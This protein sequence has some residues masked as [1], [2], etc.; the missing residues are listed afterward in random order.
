VLLAALGDRWDMSLVNILLAAHPAFAGIQVR[1]IDNHQELLL[2]RG[3]ESL[4]L[5]GKPGDTLS[6]IPV[7][8]RA[9]GITTRGLEYALDNGNLE[10]G[11][12]CGVSN[13]FCTNRASVSLRKG[14]LVCV[15][16]RN[17]GQT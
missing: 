7:R 12:P 16:I 3:G 6:L 17:G 9:E 10:F 11:S 5:S 1:M 8:G 15:V 13:E 2:L 14:L 4:E